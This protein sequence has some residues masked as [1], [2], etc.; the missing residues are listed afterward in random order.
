ME[1]ALFDA[2]FYPFVVTADDAKAQALASAE[3]AVLVAGDESILPG[4]DVGTVVDKFGS[5]CLCRNKPGNYFKLN[6][7][8]NIEQPPER[9]PHI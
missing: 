8:T 5:H 2:G 4:G 1:S 3:V 9:L 7:F 6:V